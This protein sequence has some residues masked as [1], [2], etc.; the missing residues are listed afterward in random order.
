MT[1]NNN[2]NVNNN[3]DY[4]IINKDNFA[5][6]LNNSSGNV[7][8]AV[9][10]LA[11]QCLNEGK[12]ATEMV[13]KHQQENQT[14]EEVRKNIEVHAV[15]ID[16]AKLLFGTFYNN[17]IISNEQFSQNNIALGNR[18]KEY[19]T[20]GTEKYQ[21]YFAQ[22]EQY[23]NLTKQEKDRIMGT[24]KYEGMKF[25]DYSIGQGSINELKLDSQI[26]NKV[27]NCHNKDN[28]GQYIFREFLILD[29]NKDVLNT[30]NLTY[31]DIGI[32]KNFAGQVGNNAEVINSLCDL[33][34]F[35]D[36]QINNKYDSFVKLLARASGLKA[37]GEGLNEYTSQLTKPI[38]FA[39]K[40]YKVSTMTLK[41]A[42][43]G[44][45]TIYNS[46][47]TLTLFNEKRNLE[48]LSK[49]LE[50]PMLTK[51]QREELLNKIKDK[52]INIKNVKNKLDVRKDLQRKIGSPIKSYKQAKKAQFKKSIS[53]KLAKIKNTKLYNKIINS[54]SFKELNILSEKMKKPFKRLGKLFG[55]ARDLIGN[56][57]FQ[58][59]LSKILRMIFKTAMNVVKISALVLIIPLVFTILIGLV[60]EASNSSGSVVV[61]PLANKSDFKN[62]QIN[63]DKYD[64][65]F[66]SSLENFVQN[67]S[68]NTNVKGEHVYYGING[69][70]NE[71]G[72]KNNDYQNGIYYKYLIDKEHEGR[73]SNIEDLI[74]MMA[75]IMSQQQATYKEEASKV[76]KWLYNL[77]HSYTYQE[78]SL[79]ACDSACHN[80]HYE[81]NDHYHNYTDTDIRYNPFHAVNK[82]G[83]D[84][85]IRMAENFCE[86]CS[87]T[88]DSNDSY[89]G[90][91]TNSSCRV[92]GNS[93]AT[94][95]D[96]YGCVSHSQCFH[97]AGGNMGSNNVGCSNNYPY[98]SCPGH[99]VSD[100]DGDSHTEYCD[101]PLGCDGY[102]VCEGHP[103]YS[104]D[105]HDYKCCLGHMDI[106]MNIKIKFYDELKDLVNKY[107]FGI[108]DYIAKMLNNGG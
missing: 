21:K 36:S 49:K 62:Y 35:Y 70:N 72:M 99:E 34:I 104:C 39:K 32:I 16:S 23:L 57:V 81:C 19:F 92:F 79:Y 20:E 37:M 27:R 29:G 83:G 33:Q 26:L 48:K 75:I 86:V 12:V 101:G 9:D 45:T 98:Y 38:N 5:S 102:Y 100:G 44:A 54:K 71:D 88:Y 64:E 18:I 74:S 30:N 47:A 105:G 52:T 94:K 103:H 41:G 51:A 22:A 73:S 42:W 43:A 96:Y 6:V 13:V 68:I 106:Q 77:S 56:A 67:K 7:K 46:K 8:K 95:E 58:N 93:N 63:Y 2:Q 85:E 11:V 50:N 69:M 28:N 91:R 31:S 25:G 89:Y 1:L 3:E 87:Q 66:M 82:S 65:E 14:I 78:S 59:P 40:T 60:G 84:Y 15:V 4:L 24:G 107:D 76:L 17:S 97:G 108:N 55:G 61:M 10:D 80:I 90:V 53:D